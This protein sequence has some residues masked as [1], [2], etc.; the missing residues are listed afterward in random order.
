MLLERSSE[1]E[2][3]RDTT[4]RFLASEVPV[5]KIRC[6]RDDDAGFDLDLWRR[7]AELGWTSLLAPEASG[8]GAVSESGLADLSLLAHEFGAHAAPGPLAVTNVVA[9]ALGAAGDDTHAPVLESLLAGD[10]LA[11]WCFAEPP[12]ADGL[13]QVDLRCATDGGDVVLTGVKRPV[14]SAAQAGHL[15]VTGR[16]G[17]GLTQVLVPADAA[18]LSI[19]PMRSLDLTRRF[20]TV[21]FDKVRV[22]AGAVVGELGGAAEQ[23]EHQLRLAAVLAG[24]DTVGAMQAAFDLT[25]RWT[26]DRYSFGR[27]LASYQ[28]IKHRVADLLSW[29]EAAHAINDAAVVAVASGSSDAARL[30]SAAKAFTGEYGSELAQDCVQLHGGIGLT[31]EHDLHLYLR[32]IALNRTL[33]GTPVEHRRRLADLVE[34]ERS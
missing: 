2:V 13:G 32:R 25:L 5:D 14:E 23:V 31:F 26:F 27:P 4:A 22:P 24:A 28:E 30:V 6:L 10:A 17:D 33:F 12:P 11:S 29:L 20:A 34:K 1:Q 19:E 16:T 8:G 9:A 15:L 7:G 18:G 3:L 21:R